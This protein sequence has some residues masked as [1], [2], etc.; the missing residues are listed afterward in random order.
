MD[1]DEKGKGEGG[2][3][4]KKLCVWKRTREAAR[5][6]GKWVF[7]Y[8]GL[9]WLATR[10]EDGT[11]TRKRNPT[12]SREKKE[13]TTHSRPILAHLRRIL[14]DKPQMRVRAQDRERRAPHAAAYGQHVGV[15]RE[16]PEV[17]ACPAP[18]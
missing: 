15:A 7:Q 18:V 16:L 3:G 14:H 12:E 8:C 10:Y 13:R 17:E 1:E 4:S 6:V 5:A 9:G 2:C 11:K